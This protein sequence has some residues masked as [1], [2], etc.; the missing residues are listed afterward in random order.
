MECM[1]DMKWKRTQTTFMPSAEYVL[2]NSQRKKESGAPLGRDSG[3]HCCGRFG[4]AVGVFHPNTSEKKIDDSV[5]VHQPV[6]GSKVPDDRPDIS[7]C[8]ARHQMT[9]LA[10]GVSALRNQ[11]GWKALRHGRQLCLALPPQPSRKGRGSE[12]QARVQPMNPDGNPPNRE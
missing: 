2:P 3:P 11:Q 6:I 10:V 8:L 7:G 4:S 1:A 5:K 9:D 12:S